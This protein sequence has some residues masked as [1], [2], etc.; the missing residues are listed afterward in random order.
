MNNI[1]FIGILLPFG[2]LKKVIKHELIT[3]RVK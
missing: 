1:I 3:E 2:H